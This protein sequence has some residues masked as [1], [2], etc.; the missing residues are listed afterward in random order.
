[1][2]S[3][4]IHSGLDQSELLAAAGRP[5]FLFSG[6]GCDDS[7]MV[8]LKTTAASDKVSFDATAEVISELEK[9]SA[10]N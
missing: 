10:K 5:D 9:I 7:T 1:M 3:C 6:A 8:D 2:S 4:L